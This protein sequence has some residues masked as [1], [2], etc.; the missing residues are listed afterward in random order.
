MRRL[1]RFVAVPALLLAGLLA[2]PAA[3]GA[4]PGVR[5][6]APGVR[7]AAPQ[8]ICPGAVAY[9]MSPGATIMSSTT[10]PYVGQTI[11][12]SGVNYCP[13][14][15]VDIT[16]GGKH[17]ATTHTDGNGAFEPQVVVPAPTGQRVL[18][19]VGASGLSADRD[20]LMLTIRAGAGVE[21]VAVGPTGGSGN[22][23]GSAGGSGTGGLAFTGTEIALL[24]ALAAALLGGGIGL[25]YAGRRRSLRG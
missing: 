7:A 23:A 22:G 24:I 9:P 11:K 3:A 10:T 1:I 2:V 25:M 5:A 15:D 21:A 6:S 12:V 18:A 8:Q 13:D 14:E 19:G 16:I 17:V 20:S 4:T